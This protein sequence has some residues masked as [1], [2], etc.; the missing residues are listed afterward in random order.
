[1]LQTT[2]G[3]LKMNTADDI[4]KAAA[5]VVHDNNGQHGNMHDCFDKVAQLWDAYIDIKST[6]GINAFD[7]CNMM[8]LLKIARRQTGSFNP[9][10]YIDGAGYAACAFEILKR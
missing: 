5:Q 9:D 1:M 2:I 7:V 10:D 3:E 6:S 4:L 8:E